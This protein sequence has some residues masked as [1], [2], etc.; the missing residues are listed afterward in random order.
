MLS[1]ISSAILFS[2][3]YVFSTMQV[4]ANVVPF[5]WATEMRENAERS[6]RTKVG[7]IKF[8]VTK[9]CCQFVSLIDEIPCYEWT[10]T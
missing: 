9:N 5:N 8:R 3:F 6:R 10:E 1:Q 4:C 2:M 7:N